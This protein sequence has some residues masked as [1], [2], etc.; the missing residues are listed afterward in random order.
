MSRSTSLLLTLI[1]GLILAAPASAERFY[2]WTDEKGVT[3]FSQTPPPEGVDAREVRTRNS[4]SSDQEEELERLQTRRQQA[5]EARQRAAQ[6]QAEQKTAP[7]A[8]RLERCEQHRKN[9]E[10]LRNRPIVRTEDPQTGEII[11][12]DDEGRQ[13]AIRE[14]EEALKLCN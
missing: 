8:A 5:E 6:Q 9:L 14:T 13:R 3:H 4:A 10:E 11:T 7:D 1:A 2:R 12:L